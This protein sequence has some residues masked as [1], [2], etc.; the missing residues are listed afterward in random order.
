[1]I[2]EN[3]LNALLPMDVIPDSTTIILILF[4]STENGYSTSSGIAPSPVRIRIPFSLLNSYLT[5][6]TRTGTVS[7]SHLSHKIHWKNSYWKQ[8]LIL[9]V[10]L[11]M[12]HHLKYPLF[13]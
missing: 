10:S 1:M 2:E 11:E 7:F 3:P 6:P 12:H 13:L 9:N 4:F 5:A 8:I